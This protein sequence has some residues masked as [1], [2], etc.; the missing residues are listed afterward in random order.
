MPQSPNLSPKYYTREYRKSNSRILEAKR[1]GKSGTVKLLF[2]NAF[3][4]AKAL[5]QGIYREYTHLRV[6]KFRE[7][8]KRWFLCQF[9]YHLAR[10]STNEVK[11]SR[12]ADSQKLTKEKTCTESVHCPCQNGHNVHPNY[13]FRCPTVKKALPKKKNRNKWLEC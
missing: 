13:R 4:Q 6:T 9:L 3:A 10:N 5:K 7:V 8:P 2:G 12:C 11:C 1:Y